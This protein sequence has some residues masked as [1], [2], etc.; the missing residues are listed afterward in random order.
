MPLP[1][2]SLETVG[3]PDEVVGTGGETDVCCSVH[4]SSYELL[5][6]V[7]KLKNQKLLLATIMSLRTVSDTLNIKCLTFQLH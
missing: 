6:T 7:P 1:F 3:N 5:R 4:S 2:D